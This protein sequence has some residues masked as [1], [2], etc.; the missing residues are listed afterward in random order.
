M[1]RFFFHIELGGYDTDEE[2]TEYANL[3]EARAAAVSLLGEILRDK[4]DAFWEKPQASVTVTDKKGVV[5]WKIE[6]VGSEAAAAR[7][8]VNVAIDK[9]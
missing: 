3:G 5:L 7:P 2:G 4:G 6:T 8:S 1:D 9:S